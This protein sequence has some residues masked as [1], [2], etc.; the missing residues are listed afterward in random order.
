MPDFS[1]VEF[2][3]YL[4]VSSIQGRAENCYFFGLASLSDAVVFGADSGGVVFAQP[5]ANSLKAS[6]LLATI[7]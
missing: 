6:G 2:V 4:A 1:E 7:W 5:P 3:E